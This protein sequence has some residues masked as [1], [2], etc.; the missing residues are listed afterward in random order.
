M[1]TKNTTDQ[2]T[3]WTA[4]NDSVS[5][6]V[7]TL[8]QTVGNILTGVGNLKA[9]EAVA[10]LQQQQQQQNQQQKQKQQNN[11]QP[12]ATD[13]TNII[14]IIIIVGIIVVIILFLLKQK[15]KSET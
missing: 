2:N 13:W 5:G 7:N 8:G 15:N 14:M 6:W 10:K 4:I 11:N 1:S 12:P 3:N 9:G